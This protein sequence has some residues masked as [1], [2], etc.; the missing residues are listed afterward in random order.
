MRAVPARL[1][2]LRR[3]SADTTGQPRGRLR[4]RRALDT[5][6]P[7]YSYSAVTHTTL[8]GSYTR[9][10]ITQ[11]TIMQILGPVHPPC[12]PTT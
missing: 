5:H 4:P 2:L 9:T 3:V 1:G 6:L 12:I 11:G 7:A 10:L 8:P